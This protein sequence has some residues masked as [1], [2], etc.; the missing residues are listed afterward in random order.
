MR[1]YLRMLAVSLSMIFSPQVL[2]AQEF[3][4]SVK[5]A[6]VS[7]TYGDQYNPYNNLTISGSFAAAPEITWQS[8]EQSVAYVSHYG[9]NANDEVVIGECGTTTLT[10]TISGTEQSASFQLVVNKK[11][12]TISFGNYDEEG[13][14]IE[15]KSGIT[16]YGDAFTLPSIGFSGYALSD[17]TRYILSSS[18]K[19]IIEFPI[20]N[21]DS[22]SGKITY[23]APNI[24]GAGTATIT[25]SFPG[26]KQNEPALAT[27]TLTV[28]P[29]NINNYIISLNNTSFTYTGTAITPT[30]TLQNNSGSSSLVENTD[31]TV[32]YTNNTNAATGN[33]ENPPTVTVTGKGNYNGS[34]STTF[35]IF[36]ADF[37]NIVIA[38]IDDQSYTGSAIEPTLNVTFNGNTVAADEYSATYS[39]NTNLGTATVTLMSSQKNFSESKTGISKNFNIVA[40]SI[41]NATFSTISDQ[42]YT[43]A[44]ITPEP[45]VTV[46]GNTLKKGTDYSLTYSSNIN[47]GTATIT[48]SGIGNYTGTTSTTFKI[49]SKTLTDAMV[50]LSATSFTYNGNVQKPTVT[51]TDGTTTLKEKSDYNLTNDGGT[52]V[53]T[54][55]V[56]VV[57]TGNYSGTITKNFTISANNTTLTVTLGTATYTY[58]GTAKQ[59]AVTV[60]AGETTLAATDYDVAYTNNVNAG[61]ATVSVTGKGNYAGSTGSATFTITAKALTDAMVTLS[62]TTFT[63]NGSVQKPTVTI[64]DGTTTLKE[65]TDYTLTN[66]GGTAVGTYNV[67]VV[68]KGN[69]AGTITKNFTISANSTTLSVTLG[70][71]SYTYDGTAKQP[72]V[73]IKAGQTTL[74]ATDYDVAY[75]NNVNAG[76][77]TVSV[78]GKGNYAGST[79][80]ATFTITAKALTDAMVTLSATTFTY[81]G[82]VQKPTVIVADGTTT[83]KENADYTLTNNGGT[84][85]GTYSVSVVGKGNYSGTITKNFTISA[86]STTLSVTLG[87]TSYTYDGTAKQ[88]AV[89]VKSGNTTLA[90]TDYDVAYSNNTNAGT[91]TVSVTGKGNYAGSTG[92]ATFTITAKALTDAMVA[93]SATTF[94]YNGNVQKPTVTVTDGNTALK[95]G[96]DY[97]LTNNGGTAAGTYNVSVGGKGNYTGTIT[98]S[99]TISANNTALSVTLGTTSYTY[100]GTAKQPAVTVKSGDTTLAA[101]DYDVAYTNNINAGTATVTVTGKGNYA[102]STGSATFTITAKALTDAMVT[103]SATSFTYNG[104]VQKPTVTV[105]DGNTVLKEGTDY[106]LTND[107]GTAVGTYN[108]SVAGK[109]NYAGEITK[110]FTISANSTTLNVTLGTTSYTY[111]GTAKQPEVNIKAGETTLVATDYDVAYANNINAGTATVSVTGKGNYAGSTGSAT[112][113][114]TAKALTDAMVTLSATSFTYNGNVQKPTVTVTDGNTALKEGTDYTLTNDGGTAVGTYNVVVN[115]KGNYA[116]EITKL[117]SITIET[118]GIWIGN[119]EVNADNK[120]DILEDA[121]TE[122]NQAASFSYNPNNNTLIINADVNTSIKAS[123]ELTIYLAPKSHSYIRA[124]NYTGQESARL[125][126]TTDGNFPGKLTLLTN[127][128]NVIN[129]FSELHLDQNLGIINDLSQELTYADKTLASKN[130]TIGICINPLVEEKIV[131]PTED[132]FTEKNG[133]DVDLSNT[134]IDDILY[135]LN[136]SNDDGYNTED[137]SIHLNTVMSDN[138]V[139]QAIK[140][141]PGSENYSEL[142]TGMTFIVPAGEGLI[143]INAQVESGYVIKVKIGNNPAQ[144][145]TSLSFNNPIPYNV[146]DPTF[147]YIYNG[148]QNISGARNKAIKP[149]RRKVTHIKVFNVTISPQ[150]VKAASPVGNVSGGEYKGEIPPVGQ[151]MTEPDIIESGIST[152]RADI[153]TRNGKWYNLNGQQIDEP[154]QKGLYIHNGQKVYIK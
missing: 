144:E 83:L 11:N 148:G 107:G 145:F 79:G 27:Y 153:D 55:S 108:V 50:T 105:T 142:F 71:T 78:T 109:G 70:T 18:P 12:A 88:P 110:N 152:V 63:Y 150:T 113:T 31:Y 59:P 5:E 42:T 82:C 57:G 52:A 120:N 17:T 143:R 65:G 111:D 16:T 116:G 61:T 39:N 45:T 48:A 23:G 15:E 125:I 139:E 73:T 90:A 43:G 127:S 147:V 93:L 117:F 80:S 6:S 94:I 138:E 99:F 62:A 32:S 134:V 131:T 60:K 53:G 76:T 149:G 68:G 3:S 128:G 104:N 89:T 51:V 54:Y 37:S 135:T 121:D 72:T 81:N 151:N 136:V 40:I 98:K 103:L 8:S 122:N 129:G 1:K 114:I 9:S 4:I 86:N 28:N 106:T 49:T 97:T 102:G 119:I 21:T 25:A 96:T 112:F 29:K 118:Y 64:A 30:V 91:A 47:A 24:L 92:S 46:N 124:I 10:A 146:E 137:N 38:D 133:E 132:K 67:S 69:Y 74:A 123:K 130:A 41:A 100:D 36:K 56:S 140:H 75:T 84:A 44:A 154:K 2:W 14:W 95:E 19:G 115:G 26:N 141:T 87:T 66:N 20:T 22:K 126:F 77:A 35:D 7:V 13:N 33:D 85:V 58:D 101:T 34:L